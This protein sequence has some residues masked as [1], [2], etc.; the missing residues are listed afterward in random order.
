MNRLD[1]ITGAIYRQ[2]GDE[3]Y[4]RLDFIIGST[5]LAVLALPIISGLHL[6]VKEE[7]KY[8]TP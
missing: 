7:L 2:V 8:A 3:I 4:H 1:E 5:E 6:A